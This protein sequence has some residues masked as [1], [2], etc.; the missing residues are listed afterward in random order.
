MKDLTLPLMSDNI[1]RVDVDCLIEF[2]QQ[3]PVPRLTN[4]PKVMEF[5]KAW[6]E[7][8]G[9]KHSVFVNSGT[10]ANEL[11]ML[12]LKNLYP[13]GG[14]IIIPPLTW[15][16]DV[17]SVLFAGFNPVF[18][19]IN[20]NNLSFDLD[21]LE[22]SITENTR[23][24]FVTHVLG[25]N[26]LSD[27]L[28]KLC[29]DNNILLIEDVCES[30]GATHNDIKLGS[31]GFASNFSFYFAHHMSTIEGGMVSTNDDYFYQLCRSL[32][33][34][35][36]VREFND[37]K[38]IEK[39][40]EDYPSLNQDFVFIGPAHNFRSTEINAVLG[41]SQLDR[42]DSNNESRIENFKYFVDNLDSEKY[43][44]DFEMDGQCNYAFI[45]IMKDSDF[46]LRDR[47]EIAMD[48]GGI[49]FRRG[50][51]GGGNQMRQPYFKNHNINFEEFPNIDHVHNFSWYIGNYPSLDMDKIKGLITLL[52]NQE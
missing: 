39:Y 45:V 16:S 2:L 24:I 20:L 30:H 34:H 31:I 3:E 36:M 37:D 13:E 9:V 11:S 19:D 23:A 1:N 42:L 26:A 28:L 32:R 49:E 6:S 21:Q 47:I 48:D 15:I 18:V 40:A 17:N 41:L 50:L 52:N 12:A 7:W 25:L 35:G 22:K 38:L 51:S 27:R 44:I 43:Y 29:V 14:D 33:S 46:D 8:L 5:E 4:G 10:A